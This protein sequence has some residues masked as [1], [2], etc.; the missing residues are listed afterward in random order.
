VKERSLVAP[1]DPDA[2]WKPGY[3]GEIIY[4]API[5]QS[6]PRRRLWLVGAGVVVAIAIVGVAVSRLVEDHGASPALDRI[7]TQIRERWTTTLDRPVVSVTGTDDMVVAL[8]GAELVTLDAGS[9]A[10]RWRVPAPADVGELEVIDGVVVLHDVSPERSSLTAFDVRSGRRVWSKTLRHG[11]AVTLADDQLVVPGFS[12]GGMVSSLEFLDPRTGSR[13]A[14]FEGEEIAMSSTAIRR[15]VDDRVE[16]YDRDTFDLRAG[17]ELAPL[18][19][20]LLRITGAPTDAGLVLAT[21]D[22]AWLLD[23][24]GSVVSSLSLSAKLTAP[25]S[26][27]ELDGSGRY[28][29]LQG[30]NAT[31]LLT[32]HDGR[33][34][35]LWTRP[36]A[37]VEWMTDYS[38][39]IFTAERWTDGEPLMQVVDAATGRAIFSSR[40]PR[41]GGLSLSGNGFV[42]GTDPRDDG[43]WTAVGYDFDGRELW[44]LPVP[45][46]GWPT[47]LP[48]ALLTVGYDAEVRTTRLTLLS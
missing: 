17:V 36:V 28:V 19:L 6:P 2:I 15:R 35:E 23:P 31:T 3:T 34:D 14:A 45:D 18:G 30:V 29:A 25:W 47:L 41:L 9:G 1:Q 16:W 24:H 33:L 11:P 26:I 10:E 27:D 40:P 44:R 22:R 42:A 7:P 37:P 20:D 21:F 13:L 43:T 32:I 8:A 48:G 46:R 39:T 4:P 5:Q 38:R 12:A